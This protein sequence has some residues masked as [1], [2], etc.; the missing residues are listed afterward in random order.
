MILWIISGILWILSGIALVVLGHLADR[1]MAPNE[2]GLTPSLVLAPLTIIM[3]PI[4][5]I[6][7]LLS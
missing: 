2:P 5:W 3:G 1:H 4:A 6:V 7:A